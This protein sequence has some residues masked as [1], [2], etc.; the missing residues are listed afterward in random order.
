MIEHKYEIEELKN[1]LLDADYIIDE[2]LDMIKDHTLIRNYKE[3]CSNLRNIF[4]DTDWEND[5]EEMIDDMCK[6]ADI[7]PKCFGEYIYKSY[8]ERHTELD[9]N[10][11]E[12]FGHYECQDCG[13]IKDE[14]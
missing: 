8:Y 7:C 14:D 12:E 1:E 13:Y 5:V 11:L 4:W 9:Y 2:L 3:I 10:D 6:L